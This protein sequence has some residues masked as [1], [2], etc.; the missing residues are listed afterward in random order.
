MSRVPEVEPLKVSR[1]FKSEEKW[2]SWC[3]WLV[4]DESE[5]KLVDEGYFGEYWKVERFSPFFRISS[6]AS[7]ESLGAGQVQLVTSPEVD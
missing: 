3:F 7:V 5:L 1:V 2:N 4:G 6:G